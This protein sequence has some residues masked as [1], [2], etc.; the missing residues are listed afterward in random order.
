MAQKSTTDH[1]EIKQW[2]EDHHGVPAVIK[3]TEEGSGAG[4]LR[5][6]FPEN[7]DDQDFKELSWDNFFDTF[8][9]KGLEF[10]YQD[11]KESTFHKF[12]D[13]NQN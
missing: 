13:K 4:L 3:N 8:D 12:I 9:K 2:A 10:I 1:N 7:S 11:E 5:I 6:H